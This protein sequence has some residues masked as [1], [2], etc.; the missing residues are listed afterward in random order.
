M[1]VLQ[2][3]CKQ[4]LIPVIEHIPGQGESIWG[5]QHLRL[6]DVIAL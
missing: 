1:Q 2:R 3:L 4:T 6:L 5:T